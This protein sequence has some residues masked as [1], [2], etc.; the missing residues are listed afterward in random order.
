MHDFKDEL[1]GHV[2]WGENRQVLVFKRDYAGKSYVRLRVFNRHKAKGCYYPTPRSF[3]VALES[4]FELGQV[5]ARAA[6]GRQS[7]P[8]PVWWPA[9]MAQY[10]HQGKATSAKWKRTTPSV[11]QGDA[12][13]AA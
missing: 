11:A 9:F 2:E 5:I 12:G 10:E 4:A 7:Q 3:H 1:I 13:E 6:Q 8:P